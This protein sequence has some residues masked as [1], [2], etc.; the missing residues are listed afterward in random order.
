LSETHKE[1][2]EISKGADE[3]AVNTLRVQEERLLTQDKEYFKSFIDRELKKS[4]IVK[5]DELG[6]YSAYAQEI[7]EI[8]R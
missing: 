4:Q 8:K 7:D 2:I 6:T 3:L 1:T 5:I